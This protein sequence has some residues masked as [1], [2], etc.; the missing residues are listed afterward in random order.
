[1]PGRVI[2]II[3]GGVLR[4]R[5]RVMGRIPRIV[6]RTGRLIRQLRRRVRRPVRL[7][8]VAPRGR[9]RVTGLGGVDTGLAGVVA[10]LIGRIRSGVG[11]ASGIR[12]GPRRVARL[13]RRGIGLLGRIRRQPGALRRRTSV[14]GGLARR[15]GVA[16]VGGG[17]GCSA[18]TGPW[19]EAVRTLTRNSTGCGSP[20]QREIGL[21]WNGHAEGCKRTGSLVSTPWWP[22][23]NDATRPG[24]YVAAVHPAAAGSTP[25]TPSRAS[26]RVRAW[27][28]TTGPVA[29]TETTLTL[30]KCGRDKGSS[31][32]HNRRM[33]SSRQCAP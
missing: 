24:A 18:S 17:V 27:T 10:G 7:T 30:V 13:T 32:T 6:R 14:F 8:R 16:R 29:S 3:L 19:S 23:C 28:I 5:G 11:V 2:G 31:T 1:M 21:S 22:S 4:L 9:R 25:R 33:P 12:G 26:S 20:T 15:S